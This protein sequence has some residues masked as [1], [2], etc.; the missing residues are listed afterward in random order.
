MFCVGDYVFVKPFNR[1]GYVV[2]VN[3]DLYT[4]IFA[5]KTFACSYDFSFSELEAIKNI[6]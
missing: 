3:G 6:T 4:V 5:E 2:Y 1:A